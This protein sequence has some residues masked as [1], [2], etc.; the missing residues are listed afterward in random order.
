VDSATE[1][2]NLIS[3]EYPPRAESSSYPVLDEASAFDPQ[4]FAGFDFANLFDVNVNGHNVPGFGRP[5]N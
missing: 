1:D 5:W 3:Q 2:S 4:L